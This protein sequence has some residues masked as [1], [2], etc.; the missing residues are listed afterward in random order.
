MAVVA[1][2][3]FLETIGHK[4][5]DQKISIA[6]DALRNAVQ[7]HPFYYVQAHVVSGTRRV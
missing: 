2:S 5:E 7:R 6:V 3:I 4:S 1:M